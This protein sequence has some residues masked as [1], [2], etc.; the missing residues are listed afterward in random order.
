VPGHEPTSSGGCTCGH[1]GCS[2]PGKHP[3]IATGSDHSAASADLDT[4]R[5]WGRH[6]PGCNWLAAAGE[7]SGLVVLDIDPRHGGDVSLA[8]LERVHG[9]VSRTVESLTGGDGRHLFFSHPQEGRVASKPIAPGLDVKADGGLIV[10]PPSRHASG[11]VYRWI[12]PP[13]ETAV[14]PVPGWVLDAL[15][16]RVPEREVNVFAATLSWGRTSRY[17]RAILERCLREVR[18]AS[19]GQRNDALARWAFTVGQWVGGGEIDPNGVDRLL[20]DACGDPDRRKTADTARRQLR[21]GL[22]Y[23]RFRRAAR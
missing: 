23:P 3:R 6:W 11:N 5:G 13:G 19:E 14:A 4:I 20:I 12:H 17:G 7:R 9:G 22:D 18:T 8:A 1:A 21:A 2:S 10:L 15:R 16:P